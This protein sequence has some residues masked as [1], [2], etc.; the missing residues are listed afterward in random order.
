M[1]GANIANIAN[2]EKSTTLHFGP[3][4]P[5]KTTDSEKWQNVLAFVHFLQ[6][7]IHESPILGP[8]RQRC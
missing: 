7:L 5:D 2:I 8:N 4:F 1:L 6:I 3:G